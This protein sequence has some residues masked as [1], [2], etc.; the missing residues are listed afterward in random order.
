M[1]QNLPMDPKDVWAMG[2]GVHARQSPIAQ[3]R[4]D[5]ELDPR[6]RAGVHRS[7]HQPTTRQRRV[8]TEFAQS[9]RHGLQHMEHPGGRGMLKAP[10]VNSR[11]EKE[12]RNCP[13][14]VFFEFSPLPSSRPQKINGEKFLL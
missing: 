14:P 8:A 13:F 7:R 12:S 11:I 10:L 9:E 4:R 6:Q 5:S 3:G 2:L 1:K